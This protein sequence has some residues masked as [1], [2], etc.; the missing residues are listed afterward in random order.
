MQLQKKIIA[1]LPRV[2]A[3]SPISIKGKT[4]FIAAAEEK[5]SCLLFSPPDWK[6]STIW[7]QPGGTMEVVPLEKESGAFLAVQKFYPIFQSQEACI[8][9][10]EPESSITKPWKVTKVLDLPFVHRI[11]RVTVKNTPYVIAST[12]CSGKDYQEDW[13][14]PGAVYAGPIPADIHGS[15]EINPILEG[16]T[17]NH[18]LHVTTLDGRTS[19]LVCGEEGIFNIIVPENEN[20][21]WTT[22]Q[23]VGKG[24][25]DIYAF[26]L[27]NDGNKELITIEPF[28][29]NHLKIYKRIAGKWDAVFEKKINFGHVVWGGM[30]LGKPSVI[31]GCRGGSKG[32]A[33]VTDFDSKLQNTS[34]RVIDEGTGP[35]SIK[36][37][38]MNDYELIISANHGVGEVA[39][40]TISP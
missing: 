11:G 30:I 19:I 33:M 2:Y 1:N 16:I 26:D 17:K 38:H 15:W 27:D 7:N 29:G 24:V 18:G 40:Y 37:I 13:T 3:V 6:T 23:L 9:Y 28:H 22:E 25:S 10:A 36:V 4:Y 35:A 39:F 21:P 14:K 8:V 5:G 20:E 32:L 31:F 34:C 12:L